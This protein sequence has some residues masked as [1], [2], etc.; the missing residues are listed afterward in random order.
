M[1]VDSSLHGY[2]LRPR[3]RPPG[4]VIEYV[5]NVHMLHYDES[6]LAGAPGQ[7]LEWLDRD[8][9]GDSHAWALVQQHG[10]F[11][12]DSVPQDDEHTLVVDVDKWEQARKVELQACE[13][14]GTWGE[15]I[16]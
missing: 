11:I 13:K 3:V 14:N 16:N 7:D 5:D 12:S 6:F 9:D 10:I 2:N 15:L 8:T 1:H 4:R